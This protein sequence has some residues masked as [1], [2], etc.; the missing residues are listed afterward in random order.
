VDI[1]G[2]ESLRL[3]LEHPVGL[4]VSASQVRAEWMC[5]AGQPGSMCADGEWTPKQWNAT[6]PRTRCP[7]PRLQPV[8][9][10]GGLQRP[11]QPSGAWLRRGAGSSARLH[12]ELSSPTHSCHHP[13]GRARRAIQYVQGDEPSWSVGRE[14]RL[15]PAWLASCRVRCATRGLMVPRPLIQSISPLR[16]SVA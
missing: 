4:L 16:P 13:G 14:S 6:L 3:K 9:R 15:E 7:W 1:T 8:S 2:T 10:A 12:N 5:M 11:N